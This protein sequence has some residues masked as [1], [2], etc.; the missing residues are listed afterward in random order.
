MPLPPVPAHRRPA[1][2]ALFDLGRS[3]KLP[4]RSRVP[5]AT[6][7]AHGSNKTAELPPP[8]RRCAH[9]SHQSVRRTGCSCVA[10]GT[11]PVH[12]CELLQALCVPHQ[13]RRPAE[14]GIYWCR[15]C[16]HHEP[17]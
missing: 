4:R 13:L 14:S 15:V 3:D 9:L 11:L 16:D 5:F 12:R 8:R 10:A 6:S 7:V 1:Y 2:H 17:Q